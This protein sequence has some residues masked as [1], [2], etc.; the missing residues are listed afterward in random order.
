MLASLKSFVSRIRTAASPRQIDQDFH[1]ELDTHLALLADENIRRGMAPDAARRAARLR[2]GGVTQLA[3]T[4][5]ELR[6]LPLFET[7][8]QDVRFAVRMLHKNPGFTAIAVLTLALG[9]GANT[10]IFSVIYATLLKPLPYPHSEQLFNVFQQTPGGQ[11]TG[12]SYANLEDLRR[13]A[14]VFT[15]IAAVQAHQLTLTGLGEPFVVNTSVVTSQFFSLFQVQPLAGRVF[16]PEDGKPGAAPVVVLSENLWR[17]AFAADP[18]IIGTSISLDKRSFT[19]VGVVPAAFRFPQIAQADQIWIP[20]PADPLFGPWMPRRGGHWLQVVGRLK[21]GVPM[22]QV[23][24]ELDAIDAHLISEFPAEN[25]GW[26]IR[27]APLQGAIMGNVRSALLVLLG[28]VGLVLLIACANIANLLLARATSRAREIAVRATLG[29]AR[30]RIVRQLLSETA[31]LGLLGGIAG[32]ALAY[33]GVRTLAVLLPP[34]VPQINPIRVDYFVLG[35]ALLL[36]LLSSAGFGLAPALFAANSNLQA[37]LREGGSRAGETKRSHRARSFLAAGEMALATVLLVAAGLLL[38]SFSKLLDVNP[39]FNVQQ[40]VKAEVSLPRT[41]YSTPQQWLGFS[42]EL[43]A[44]I[45]AE[46]GLQQ[47]AVAVPVPLADGN[48]NLGFDIVGA[49]A[50]T[51]A[52]NRTANYVSV[53]SEYFR[54]MGI[55]LLS[56]RTFDQRDAMSSPRVT[57]ISKA[58][59][60]IYFRDQDPIGHQLTFGFPPEPTMPR[61]IIG[62]VGDVRDTSLGADPGPMMYVPF[63]QAP[64][65]GAVLVAK[66]AVGTAGFASAIRRTVQGLDKDLP[67]TD[68]AEMPQVL[69]ASVSQERFRTGLLALFAGMALILAATGIFGVISYSVSRRT[70]EIGIR[71]ALGASRPQILTMVLRETLTLA[72]IG[73][74]LGV[75]A[76]L[77]ASRLLGHLLFNI[78]ASDPATVAAVVLSLCAVALAAGYVPARR[79]VRI[80]PL[81]ALRHE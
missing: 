38:R 15:D 63:A 26:L 40:I 18:K 3:E 52:E 79:A 54:V 8:A 34:G 19:V 70:N 78:S 9:I 11:I 42:D 57:L 58:M 60:R 81:R 64:F 65:P 30:A 20:L 2:L 17:G 74:A 14:N 10:A 35:F 25:T 28:A 45:H 71:V 76:S 21:S 66:S 41:Q 33:C 31:V 32:V 13:Q 55:P 68:I 22:P 67:V 53:S 12:W 49:P 73:L 29:A 39:G 5:R 48:V 75:P 43:L 46:P 44:R 23:Q 7:L 27:T 4:N 62:V 16:Y 37:S 61:Q 6:G 50:L 77:A 80:D 24:A 51:V 59:A 69:D 56:G 1:T 72:L 47:A 36:A